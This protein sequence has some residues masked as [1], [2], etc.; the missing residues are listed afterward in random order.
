MVMTKQD[1]CV[2][3]LM[4]T[5]KHISTRMQFG[6]LK[7]LTSLTD[8]FLFTKNQSTRLQDKKKAFS[9]EV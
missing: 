8:I 4:D 1:G 7:G 3:F 5:N 2:L 9:Q 6:R